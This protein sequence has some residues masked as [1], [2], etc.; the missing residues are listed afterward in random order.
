[1]PRIDCRMAGIRSRSTRSASL[2][3]GTDGGVEEVEDASALEE[4]VSDA[5][6]VLTW[7]VSFR[8]LS[9]ALGGVTNGPKVDARNV[10]TLTIG[11]WFR[12]K[13]YQYVIN[14]VPN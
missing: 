4:V 12:E 14:Q 5:D 6:M 9:G 7:G 2:A 8:D 1:M 11:R 3:V 10:S 13:S